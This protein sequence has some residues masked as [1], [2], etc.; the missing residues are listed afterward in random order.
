[1]EIIFEANHIPDNGKYT[2]AFVSDG[3]TT[4]LYSCNGSWVR[5]GVDQS[6]VKIEPTPIRETYLNNGTNSFT[7]QHT[8]AT[9]RHF[10]VF[11]NGLLIAD[12]EYSRDN[13]Q[14]QILTP[15]KDTDKV[16][17]VYYR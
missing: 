3:F 10:L 14:V 1:M 13:S 11:V 6:K 16:S 12:E 9:N 5:L 2:S 15:L 17:F 4:Y 7:I 8:P